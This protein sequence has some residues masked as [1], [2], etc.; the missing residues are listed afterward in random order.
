MDRRSGLQVSQRKTVHETESHPLGPAEVQM[1][2][3]G[4]TEQLAEFAS[5]LRLHAADLNGDTPLHIVA[6]MGQLGLCELF[7]PAGADLG[8]Q[9]HGGRHLRTSQLQRATL[10]FSNHWP[11]FQ[12]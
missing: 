9:N 11:T 3:I 2:A 6:R 7:V 4:R 8:A 5:S 10:A 12:R 1:I